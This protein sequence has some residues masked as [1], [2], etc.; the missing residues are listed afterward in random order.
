MDVNK[1]RSMTPRWFLSLATRNNTKKSAEVFIAEYRNWMEMGELASQLSP[2]LNKIDSEEISPTPGLEAIKNV[3]MGHIIASGIAKAE[4]SINK[5]GS[6]VRND[7]PYI[8][9]IFDATG[10]EVFT[11][12]DKEECLRA[13][14]EH[15]QEADRW[16]Q[17]RLN[18][19][20]PNWYGEV[21]WTKIQTKNGTPMVTRVERDAAIAALITRKRTP[22]MHYNKAGAGPLK[23]RMRVSPTMAKFSRG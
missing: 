7:K 9:Q 6:G 17:R 23:P 19:G 14:F 22:Y 10:L 21:T 5:S 1:K 16:C 2:I 8:A 18:E 4:E 13:S 15:P 20:E 3:V 11:L 12:S